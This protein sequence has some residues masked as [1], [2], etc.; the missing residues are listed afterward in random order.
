MISFDLNNKDMSLK[1]AEGVKALI[2]DL[3][4]TLADTMPTHY[5]AWQEVGKKYD[6]HFP[7]HLFYELAGVPTKEITVMLNKKYRLDLDPLR[8]EE[9]KEQSYLELAGNTIQPIGPVVKI[10][11]DNYKNMPVACGTGNNREIALLTLEAIGLSGIF[12]IIITADDVKQPKPNPETFLECAKLMNVN[13]VYCQV[14]EDGEP[15]LFA[16][17]AAGMVPTDVRPFIKR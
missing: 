8:T 9:E 2:F 15:G 13:P 5:L 14:F 3:D 17:K 16:A 12:K 11:K 10:L 6:F 7:E 4:G 1:I